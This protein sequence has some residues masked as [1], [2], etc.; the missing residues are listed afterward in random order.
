MLT[1]PTLDKLQALRLY[2]MKKA[3]IEQDQADSS[4]LSFNERFGLLVDREMLEKENK[5]M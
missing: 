5:N 1:Q 4:S 2:G 3:L